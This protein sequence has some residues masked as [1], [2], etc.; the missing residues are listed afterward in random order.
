M[1][2]HHHTNMFMLK[3]H[4]HKYMTAS[5]L[6]Q[7]SDGQHIKSYHASGNKISSILQKEGS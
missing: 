7:E 3:H 2:T 6:Q 1:H 4:V 5:G